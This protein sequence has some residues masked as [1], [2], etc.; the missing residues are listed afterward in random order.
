[1]PNPTPV[2]S[3]LSEAVNLELEQARMCPECQRIT[4]LRWCPNCAEN[5]TYPLLAV[6]ASVMEKK[7]ACAA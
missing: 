3:W 7:K 6:L 4:N 5:R 1:M 2:Q